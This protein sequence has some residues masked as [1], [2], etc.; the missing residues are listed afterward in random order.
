MSTVVISTKNQRA[1]SRSA[2]TFSFT[3]A[4]D[5]AICSADLF[6]LDPVVGSKTGKVLRTVFF[7]DY[8]LE[9]TTCRFFEETGSF[10]FDMISI[11]QIWTFSY[12]RFESLL[13]LRE[14]SSDYVLAVDV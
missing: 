1:K 7:C 10:R 12:N 4:Y 13:S 11:E 2:R 6:H 3:P 8:S 9:T 5:Y 14:R